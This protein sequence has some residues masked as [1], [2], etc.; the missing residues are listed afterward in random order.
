MFGVF[1]HGFAAPPAGCSVGVVVEESGAGFVVCPAA[2][3]LGF[4]EFAVLHAGLGS[5]VWWVCEGLNLMDQLVLAFVKVGLWLADCSPVESH[6]LCASCFDAAVFFALRCRV[7]SLLCSCLFVV[8]LCSMSLQR[9]FHL[10][11]F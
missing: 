10:W 8:L 5:W 1:V 2:A 9:F 7:A 11:S 3:L 6:P 4:G